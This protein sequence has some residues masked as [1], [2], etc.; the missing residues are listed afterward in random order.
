MPFGLTKVKF[1]DGLENNNKYGD[2]FFENAGNSILRRQVW[3][4]L[5]HE[6]RHADLRMDG[7]PGRRIG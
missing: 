2:N 7:W 1:I 5:K 6:S 3:V 4:R